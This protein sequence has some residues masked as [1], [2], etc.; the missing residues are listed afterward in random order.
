MAKRNVLTKA[1]QTVIEILDYLNIDA[2]LFHIRYI[3]REKIKIN[4]IEAKKRVQN[5]AFF[6]KIDSEKFDDI[7]GATSDGMIWVHRSMQTHDDVVEILLHEVLHD[8]IN[9]ERSTRSGSHKYL[10]ESFEHFIMK[11]IIPFILPTKNA[12]WS[13]PI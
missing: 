7:S 9:I 2:M 8:L 12:G 5:A 11:D 3:P 10:S 6:S 4:L 13:I 1:K